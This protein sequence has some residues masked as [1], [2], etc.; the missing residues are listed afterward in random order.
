[1]NA[2]AADDL[3]QEPIYSI[4]ARRAKV[5][6]AALTPQTTLR[7]LGMASIAAI[8]VLF[9]IEEHF[10]IDFAE[11]S[12]SIDNGNLQDLVNA[13]RACLPAASASAASS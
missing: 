12:E 13:V 11:R 9:D 6:M 4:V 2:I 5:E 10:N 1:M 7:D 8:E 3:V